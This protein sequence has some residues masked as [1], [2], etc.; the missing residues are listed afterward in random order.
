MGSGKHIYVVS[1]NS[2]DVKAVDVNRVDVKEVDVVA[3]DKGFSVRDPIDNMSQNTKSQS[4]RLRF[5]ANLRAHRTA[6]QI[7]QE[8]L[9]EKAGFHRTF[10]SHVE[11]GTRSLSLDNIE[12][13]AQAL[14]IDPVQLFAP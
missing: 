11:R 4:L 5:A 3:V 9:G 1:A 8:A 2:V 10:V 7:S 13:L 6:K 12:R 14:E